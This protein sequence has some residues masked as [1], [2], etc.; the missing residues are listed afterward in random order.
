MGQLIS[1]KCKLCDFKNDFKFGGNRYDYKEKCPIPAINKGTDEFE[2]VNYIEQKTNRNYIFY[3]DILLKGD[4]ENSG[5]YRNFN[6]ELNVKNN[7]CPKCKNFALD[8]YS[9]FFTD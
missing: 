5:V 9:G 3:S 7:Y 6:L 4:N 1:S 2:V 8:F